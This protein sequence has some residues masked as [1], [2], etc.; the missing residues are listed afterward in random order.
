MADDS[1]PHWHIP[2]VYKNC[3][4]LAAHIPINIHEPITLQ[5]RLQAAHASN[6][7][8][9]EGARRMVQDM[10]PLVNNDDSNPRLWVTDEILL[11]ESKKTNRD[12]LQSLR[13]SLPKPETQ[14]KEWSKYWDMVQMAHI[15]FNMVEGK[16]V[17]KSIQDIAARMTHHIK[18]FQER[19]FIEEFLQ[20][21]HTLEDYFEVLRKIPLRFKIIYGL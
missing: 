17:A 8:V 3:K 18:G 5:M 9:R 21:V 6:P 16:S 7:L 13:K 20:S 14:V 12:I 2:D 4:E 11:E 19:A 10:I 1:M 15:G